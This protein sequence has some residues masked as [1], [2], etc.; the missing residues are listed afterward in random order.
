MAHFHD[1]SAHC[2]EAIRA[3]SV[4]LSDS[5]C[6]TLNLSGAS[7]YGEQQKAKFNLF[8]PTELAGYARAIAAAINAVPVPEKVEEAA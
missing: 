1:P 7:Y 2:V 6:L 5:H 8:M 3:E 4:A